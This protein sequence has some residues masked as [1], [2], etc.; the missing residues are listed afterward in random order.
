MATS[1]RKVAILVFMIFLSLLGLIYT[2]AMGNAEDSW[3]YNLGKA[4]RAE[5]VFKILMDIAQYMQEE[6]EQKETDLVSNLDP[7]LRAGVTLFINF[8]EE[9]TRIVSNFSL[10]C[11]DLSVKQMMLGE[12]LCV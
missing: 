8:H 12:L 9:N 4:P 2:K 7:W 6:A 1:G 11:F 3:I 5:E 10:Q